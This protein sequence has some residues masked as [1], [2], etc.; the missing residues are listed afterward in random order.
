MRRHTLLLSS[1][2]LLVNGGALPAAVYGVEHRL[3]WQPVQRYFI[4][5][6]NDAVPPQGSRRLNS[7]TSYTHLGTDFGFHGPAEHEIEWVNDQIVVH[8]GQQ[9]D[10]WAGMWHSLAG[11]ARDR[12]EVLDFSRAYPPQIADDWQPRITQIMVDA[13]G[14]GNLKLEIKNAAGAMLWELIVTYYD[15][16]V[17]PQ[18]HPVPSQHLRD[19]K[20]LVWTVEPGSEITVRGLFLGVELP[21]LERDRQAFATSY[22]KLLRNHCIS[23]GFTRDR[24]HLDAGAFDS[25]AATGLMVLSTAA[26]AQKE[27]ALVSANFARE[28]LRTTHTAVSR[29]KRARG[30]LPHFIRREE[31]GFGIHPHTEHSTVDTALYT[32]CL[33]LAARMLGELAIEEEVVAMIRQIDIEGLRLPSGHLSHGLNT[34]GDQLL[35]HGWRDWGGET[36]LVALLQ[37][38]ARPGSAISP[39][40]HP[41]HAW[42][43]TGFITE[44]QSLLHPDFASDEPDKLDG[45]QWLSAR[46]VMLGAQQSYFTRAMPRSFAARLGFYGLSAG[47]NQFGNAYFVGGV[48]LVG[49]NLIH[50]HYMLMCGLVFEKPSEVLQTL[51][52]LEKAGFMPPWGLV[53]N[54]TADGQTYLPMNGAL[55]AAFEALGIYH[56]VTKNRGIPDRIYEASLQCP[57]IREAM[58]LFYSQAPASGN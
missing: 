56:F 4:R 20:L 24:A 40:D 53:E 28:T 15:E 48:D 45:V 13:G 34:K 14:R 49:Q 26:A 52:R 8:L 35:A 36:A 11:Q 5:R 2:M 25:I 22:A 42:Q 23:S 10:V 51:E 43:G 12:Q 58:N 44:I 46:R 32:Q 57:A 3:A 47:E 29:L 37:R 27:I 18:A 9:P 55:N 7:F 6:Q 31:T 30:L 16:P 41:G 39:A 33:L 21:R 17:H 1:L 38:I 50:P 54:L 19:A